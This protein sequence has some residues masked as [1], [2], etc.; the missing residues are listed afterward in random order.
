VL[1]AIL[2]FTLSSIL[3]GVL[4]FTGYAYLN[5]KKEQIKKDKNSSLRDLKMV[6]LKQIAIVVVGLSIFFIPSARLYGRLS[7]NE[8]KAEYTRLSSST[9]RPLSERPH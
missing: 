2:T 1:E 8:S 5:F 3:Y 9:C 6:Q 7:K 4:F